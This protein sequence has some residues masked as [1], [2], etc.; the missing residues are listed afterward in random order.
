MT[1]FRHAL[2]ALA[3]ARSV[4]ALSVLCLAIGIG[5]VT[6]V[7]AVV[8][9][10]LLQ[11]LPFR[12][13]EQLLEITAGRPAEE[14][15]GS[16]SSREFDAW[17]RLQLPADLAALHPATVTTSLGTRTEQQPALAVSWN[18][19]AV[20]GMDLV[21]GRT[22]RA[23]ED[24]AGAEG[25]VLISEPFWK[26]HFASDPSAIGRSLLLNGRPAVVIGIVPRL[27][28]PG[29]PGA[30][31][32]ARIWIPLRST[33]AASD[34]SPLTVIA[35]RRT[36]GDRQRPAE[37]EDRLQ[38][39][40]SG[41]AASRDRVV[42]AAPLDLSVSP[43][44]RGML[45][46]AMGAAAFVLL[47]GCA[48]VASLML[49]R[50]S[51]RQREMATRAALGASRLR[52]FRQVS[53]ESALVGL[54]S[55]PV[56]V[57]LGWAGRNL[58]LAGDGAQLADIAA[59]DGRVAAAATGAALLT[60]V[61]FGVAPVLQSL[62]APSLTRRDEGRQSTAGGLQHRLR[63]A[64]AVTEIALSLVLLVSTSLLARSFANL[65]DADRDLDLAR[66]MVV[67]LGDPA[68]RQ[69]S[70]AETARAS[71][72]IQ[73]RVRA[74]PNVAAA[75]L[76][77]FMPL[78]RGGP[79]VGVRSDDRDPAARPAMLLQSGIG[80]EFF[81]AIGMALEAGRPFTADEARSRQGV[82]VLN[83]RAAD[84]LWPGQDPVGR[85]F[86]FENEPAVVR[87]VIGVARNISNWDISG[88]PQPTAYVPI[89][90]VSQARRVLI[91]R[92]TGDPSGLASPV[93]AIVASFDRSGHGAE[94][95][96]M[97]E[98]SRAA[99]SRQETLTVLFGVF[100]TVSVVLTTVGVYSVLSCFV[101]QRRRELGIRAALG[102]TRARLLWLVGR[103]ALAAA[104]TGIG[105]GVL[106]AFAA[107]RVL[108]NILFEVRATDPLSYNVTA[109]LIL[110]VSA[111]AAWS[112]AHRAASAD[113][114]S[115][116]RE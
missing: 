75:A 57:R 89:P 38:S 12:D 42:R 92:S 100:S 43:T 6:M 93:R 36:A 76:A 116:L 105:I 102:A 106:L 67:G 44:T 45:L 53:L 101:S 111:L 3:Q 55:A 17:Q 13:H 26:S 49:L 11:P 95:Q 87:T 74:L 27:S 31:R 28:H 25:V 29:L 65:L 104:G 48:N 107:T 30:L 78:R 68:E 60:S 9:G 71:E 63:I 24:T 40:L 84:L 115:T 81:A 41:D 69:E 34:A 112:P 86:R 7:F 73:A 35:R 56:G 94:P 91:V 15:T 82:A 10:V 51:A 46:T 88:R 99:F 113:P 2:R 80:A 85:R 21:A 58:L 108:Q 37:L 16:I 8:N 39:A 33:R 72:E 90:D 96:P 64:F 47:I 62:R 50:S 109:V 18:V 52:I 1:D 54:A 97:A 114:A 22:F 5:V 59:I 20:L 79:R 32:T 61:V 70:P 23:G 83:R 66:L 103:Q 19:T 98:I 110:A 14:G 4:V 77:E